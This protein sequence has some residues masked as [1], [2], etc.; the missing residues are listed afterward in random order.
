M[1]DGVILYVSSCG[2]LFMNSGVVEDGP[3]VGQIVLPKSV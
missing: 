2:Q 3:V 1:L